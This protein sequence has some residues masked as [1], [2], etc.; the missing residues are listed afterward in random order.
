MFMFSD[1]IASHNDALEWVDHYEIHTLHITRGQLEDSKQ[2]T[3][4]AWINMFWM[5]SYYYYLLLL[6]CFLSS[7]SFPLFTM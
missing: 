6:L 4:S 5:L 2:M 3:P 1:N 7:L